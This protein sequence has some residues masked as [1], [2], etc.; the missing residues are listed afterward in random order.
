MSYITFLYTV[1]YTV[2]KKKNEKMLTYK[3]IFKAKGSVGGG[4]ERFLKIAFLVRLM[5]FQS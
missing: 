5:Y 3:M 4:N 2:Y 1:S